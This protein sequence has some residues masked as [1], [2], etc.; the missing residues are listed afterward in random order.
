MKR[1]LPRHAMVRRAVRR[2][3]PGEDRDA[4]LVAAEEFQGQRIASILTLLGENVR[5]EAE[6]AEVAFHYIGLL[7]AI[8]QRRIDAEVSVKL[9]HLGLDLDPALACRSLTAI[10]SAP[11]AGDSV[12]WV[13]MESSRYTEPTLELFDRVRRDHPNLGLCIQSYLHRTA[14]DLERLLPAHL[15][16]VKGAYAEPAEVAF[17]R[18]ADVD[19][20]FLELARRIV[21]GRGTGAGPRIAFGTHDRVLIRRIID[22]AAA[23]GVAKDALE[24]QMLYGIQREEQRRLA[25]SGHRVRVLISYGPAWF[26]WYMRRLAERPANLWFVVK[27]AFG[28]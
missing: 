4:A 24:F 19:A 26:P 16:L 11:A 23:Q 15:R 28:R 21:A 12:V 27:N 17:P 14:R 9:T 6:A 22:E 7:Q 20:S 1:E 5:D 25:A 13:D 10:V 8:R 2:F 3:M 18:K